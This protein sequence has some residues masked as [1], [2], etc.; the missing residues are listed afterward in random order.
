MKITFKGD[1]P[2]NAGR[3]VV[4]LEIP[5]ALKTVPVENLRF[6]GGKIVDA[7]DVRTFFVD[8]L[9]QKHVNKE[10]ASWTRVDCGI[11]DPLVRE[12]GAWRK[13]TESDVLAPLIKAECRRRIFAV[14]DLETQVN[15][16][17]V[18]M[19]VTRAETGTKKPTAAARKKA[20]AIEIGLGW[21]DDMRAACKAMIASGETRFD[22]DAK[23]PAAPEGLQQLADEV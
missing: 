16:L 12:N 20:D 7:S 13:Q 8:E 5:D 14:V 15:L 6:V 11:S 17:R 19:T 1:I 23:W 9:G 3:T 2:E 22:V 18:Q 21:I 4:G 10:K